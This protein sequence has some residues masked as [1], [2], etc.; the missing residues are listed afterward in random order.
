[1]ASVAPPLDPL[2]QTL[3]LFLCGPRL[4]AENPSLYSGRSGG[5]RVFVTQERASVSKSDNT[6]TEYG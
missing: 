2:V 5:G 4:T 6:R 3:P 1:M